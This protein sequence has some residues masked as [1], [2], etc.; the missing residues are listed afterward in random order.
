M[1]FASKRITV[2]HN[3]STEIRQCS[4]VFRPVAEVYSSPQVLAL[5]KF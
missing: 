5:H 1:K 2:R 3:K 4:P